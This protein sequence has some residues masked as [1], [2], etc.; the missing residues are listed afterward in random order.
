[1]QGGKHIALIRNKKSRI[2]IRKEKENVALNI[3][4]A[5]RKR[6]HTVS[7]II[8]KTHRKVTPLPKEVLTFDVQ[9]VFLPLYFLDF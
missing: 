5:L 3:A 1:L 6:G 4:Q 8:G 2:P 7:F 9:F